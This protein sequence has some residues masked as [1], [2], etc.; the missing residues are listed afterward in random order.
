MRLG[1]KPCPD[2]VRNGK[3]GADKVLGISAKLGNLAGSAD[4]TGN[5]PDRLDQGETESCTA[6][7]TAGAIWNVW[8]GPNKGT[9]NIFLPSPDQVFKVSRALERGAGLAFGGT[10]RALTDTGV[11]LSTVSNAISKFGVCAFG[12]PAT[13]GRHSDVDPATVN[14]EPDTLR[15]VQAHRTLVTGEYRIDPADP[16]VID[17]LAASLE[18]GHPVV[19]GF[20]ADSAFMASDGTSIMGIPNENDPNGGGHAVYLVAYKTNPDGSRVFTLT[21]SWGLSWGNAGRVQVSETFLRAA[22]DFYPCIIN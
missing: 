19:M 15:L 12:T 6:H 14:Q 13:D 21:N 20:F 22:W 4:L 9:G 16:R 17:L 11:A 18:A 10:L 5:D 2:H 1:C 7:A 3:Q 8:A